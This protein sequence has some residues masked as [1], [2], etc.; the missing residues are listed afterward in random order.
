MAD[1]T[2]SVGLA[3]ISVQSGTAMDSPT[4][5][6][7]FCTVEAVADDGSTWAGQLDPAT[8]REMAMQFLECAEAADQ[9]AIVFTMLTRDIGLEPQ[10]AGGFVAA[11]RKERTD[12]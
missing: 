10:Q 9:D 6:R 1:N 11:M 4:S 7:G 3:G 12:G 2:D 8:L 5:F